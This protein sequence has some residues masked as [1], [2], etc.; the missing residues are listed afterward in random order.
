MNVIAVVEDELYI[1]TNFGV[2]IIC[3][4]MSLTPIS[5]IR[6]FSERIGCI[7]PLQMS[8]TNRGL[9]GSH[10]DRLV[11]CSGKGCLDRWNRGKRKRP[12]DKKNITLLTWFVDRWRA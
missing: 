6:C 5:S 4:G 2:M 12:A 11:L 7:I 1:G 9:S 8:F 10:R 3:D